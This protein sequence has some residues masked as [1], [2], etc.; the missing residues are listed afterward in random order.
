MKELFNVL[1]R[2]ELK[3][4][5]EYYKAKG[6]SDRNFYNLKA[7]PLTLE[8]MQ[9]AYDMFGLIYDFKTKQISREQRVPAYSMEEIDTV[10][11]QYL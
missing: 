8:A 3:Q 10:L 4:L 11:D 5:R 2:P 9:V 7:K 1:T 6:V